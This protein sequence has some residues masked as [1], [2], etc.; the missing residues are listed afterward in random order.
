MPPVR[1]RFAPSPTGLTHLGSA[2]TALFN[3][4]I[5]KQ[6][7]GQFIFRIEDTDQKR[8]DPEAE[9]DLTQSLR[10]LGIEWDEGPDVG[11]PHEPYRQSERS[12]IYREHAEKLVESGHAFFCFCTPAEL[13]EVRKEQQGRKEALRYSGICRTIDPE[14][15]VERVNNGESHVVR[16]KMPKEGSITAQ[17]YLRGDIR[18]ENRTMDDKVLLKSDGHALYHLAALVDDHI[19]GITHVFRGEE[20]LPSLP[21]HAHI[22]E[23][24]GWDQPIWVHLSVFLKPTGKGK[25]SK[26]ETEA[27]KGSGKSIFVRDFPELGYLPEAVNNWIALMGWSL[28]DHTEFFHMEDL[29]EGFSL[30]GLNPAPAAIDFK[31]LDHFNGLHIRDLSNDELAKQLLPQYLAAGVEP[32][33]EILTKIMPL[34][35]TRLATLDDAPALTAFLFKDEVNID[36]ED[37]PGKGMDFDQTRNALE[38]SLE[39]MKG[40]PAFEAELMDSPMRELA[41]NLGLKAGQLF[42]SLRNA[43][44]GQRISPPLFESM[45]LLGKERTFARINQAIGKLS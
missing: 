3:Y 36:A 27:M 7:G 19:M 35:Q 33:M 28:D 29:I 25:M 38:K 39:L 24:F 40:L 43:V 44:T 1:V 34:I 22:Y 37:I 32:E 31:K 17:D 8:F 16:F 23:A 42:T 5:A 21:L 6:T 10:W 15:A 9:S 11:G 18:V 26:R 13:A 41:E 2:R 14:R 4:L 20:W 12:Q 30:E 45:E